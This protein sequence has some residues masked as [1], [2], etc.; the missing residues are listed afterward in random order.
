MCNVVM[1]GDDL[2]FMKAAADEVFPEYN[3]KQMDFISAPRIIVA[4]C[5]VYCPRLVCT[6]GEF[7]C[8]CFWGDVCACEASFQ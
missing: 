7:N 1:M 3:V 2:A 8:L 6:F 5:V 4:R